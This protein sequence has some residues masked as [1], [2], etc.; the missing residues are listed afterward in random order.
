MTK[1]IEKLTPEQEARIPVVCEEWRKV[2]LN[3][4][5][6]DRKKAQEA[7]TGLYR[8]AGMDT[9]Q[10]FCFSSPMACLIARALMIALGGRS[11][12]LFTQ[13]GDSRPNSV[14]FQFE[15]SLRSNFLQDIL[16]GRFDLKSGKDRLPRRYLE[17]VMTELT[18]GTRSLDEIRSILV[19]NE[20][21]IKKA[22]KE[23]HQPTWLIGGWDCFWVAVYAFSREIGVKYT[24]NDH[25]DAYIAY[26]Q[27]CGIMYPYEGVAFVS[28]RPAG[29][30]FDEN[31]ELHAGEEL[32]V[33]FRDGWGWA[34]WHGTRIPSEWII[35]GNLTA[36]MALAEQNLELRRCACEI[37]GWAKILRE[38]DAKVINESGDPLVGDLLEVDLPDSGKER[39]LRVQ[40][41]TGREF[42]LSV[43]PDVKTALEAQAA[44][45]RA[46]VGVV[47]TIRT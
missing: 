11:A 24:N 39:F 21:S 38:L 15:R 23:A 28:D 5:P 47:P 42:A 18:R 33:S 4:A 20:K 6:M 13:G 2:G 16:K 1:K 26:A 46:P 14:G 30:K 17:N 37:F 35:E 32:A 36:R 10:V 29:I 27:E 43:P 3:T 45:N 40:C 7:V 31:M 34:S 25:L 44:I 9:P 41:G 19:D 8:A 12:T 22:L